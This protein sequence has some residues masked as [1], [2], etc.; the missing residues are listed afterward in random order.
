[1]LTPK[2]AARDTADTVWS[3]TAGLSVAREHSS[4]KKAKVSSSTA[5][6]LQIY[7]IATVNSGKMV[8]QHEARAGCTLV[9][10]API[11]PEEDRKKFERQLRTALTARPRLASAFSKRVGCRSSSTRLSRSSRHKKNE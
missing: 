10:N 9:I 5:D 6:M 8:E 3:P 1:M 2:K 11:G 4:K 7:L